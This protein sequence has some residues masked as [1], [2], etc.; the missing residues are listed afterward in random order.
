MKIGPEACIQITVAD[1]CA[2]HQIPFY[3][4]ANE[5]KSSIVYGKL[6]KRM[7]VVSGFSDCFL[8]RGNA[9]FKGLFLE[10]KSGKNKPTENQRKF[11]A[12]M[13]AEG[14]YATWCQ[15][16]DAAIAI[17]KQFYSIS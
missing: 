10:L 3:H 1:F 5:R 6:L 11:M 4:I 16:V 9:Q 7:G 2:A 12:L 14:Y 15:G 13:E 8:P 17:I